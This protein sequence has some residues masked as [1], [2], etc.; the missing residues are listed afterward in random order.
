MFPKEHKSSIRF[1]NERFLAVEVF[2]ECLVRCGEPKEDF[3]LYG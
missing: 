2:V 1:K 3:D